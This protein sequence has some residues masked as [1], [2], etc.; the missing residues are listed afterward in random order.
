MSNVKAQMS[1]EC[2]MTKF[3]MVKLSFDTPNIIPNYL[4]LVNSA[5]QAPL[6]CIDRVNALCLQQQLCALHALT[7]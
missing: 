5:R 1:N 3:Q 2:Q 4:L 7:P 6:E